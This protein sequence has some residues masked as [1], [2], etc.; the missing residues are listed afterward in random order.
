MSHYHCIQRRD[1]VWAAVYAVGLRLVDM[2][3]G[4]K[5]LNSVMS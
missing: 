2:A 5:M 4:M 3:N 1:L